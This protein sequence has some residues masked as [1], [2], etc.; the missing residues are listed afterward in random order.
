MIWSAKRW[1]R[2]FAQVCVTR[3]VYKRNNYLQPSV[4]RET[5]D[6][7]IYRASKDQ[8]Q[9]RARASH[10]GQPS[11]RPIPVVLDPFRGRCLSLFPCSLILLSTLGFRKSGVCLSHL[12]RLPHLCLPL[13]L[14]YFL[15]SHLDRRI[16]KG[17]CIKYSGP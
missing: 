9:D 3:P 16:R 1:G 10:E 6:M 11:R 12:S 4:P 14:R 17:P 7:L 5:G 2:A 13:P 8:E 15:F